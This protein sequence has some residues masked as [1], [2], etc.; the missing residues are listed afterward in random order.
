[1]SDTKILYSVA[2]AARKIGISY[3]KTRDLI[4]KKKIPYY[5][6]DGMI[7]VSEDAIDAFLKKNHVP[8][9]RKNK[10]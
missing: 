6:F 2:G 9:S 1:M 5:N 8:V 3:G 4:R 7:R 10:F